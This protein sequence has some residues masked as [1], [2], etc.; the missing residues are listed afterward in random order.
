MDA[1]LPLTLATE[2]GR[3]AAEAPHKPF[4]R[5]LHRE[6]TFQEVDTLSDAAAAGFARL[7]VGLQENVSLLLPNCIE[8]A[9]VW[10]GLAK[11]G[12][13]A[14]PANTAFRGAVLAQAIDLVDSRVLVVHEDLLPALREVQAELSKI[15]EIVVVSRSHRAPAD[16]CAP[17]TQWNNLVGGEPVAIAPCELPFSALTL[18]LYTSG[19]TGRSKAAMI[20]HRFVLEQARLTVR[21][22]G[23][24]TDDVLYCPYPMFH[25]DS[26]VM[27]IAPALVLRCVAAIG[28]RFSV[29][30]YWQEMCALRATVFD[31]M[32]A[33]LTMLWK[34]PPS[35]ADRD[36]CARLGWGVPLPAWA[37]EFEQ[38][39][40]C[41]LVELYGSTEAGAMIFTPLDEARRPGSC[42]KPLGPFDLALLDEDGFAVPDGVA[43]ELV[44][45]PTAPSMLM[46]GYYA[47]PQETLQ[48]FRNLWFHT[49][50]LLKRDADGYLYFVGRRK[51]M[52]RRRG[53]NI[54][55]AEVEM[56]VEE[57]PDI[58][59]CAVYGVPSE[60]TEEEVMVCAVVREGR[61]LPPEALADHCAARMAK[62]MVPRF[63][64]FAT[65][66]PKTP[67]D[68]VEKFWLKQEGV[69]AGT[70]DREKHSAV[71]HKTKE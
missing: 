43:G 3:A 62:F 52:V 18:L 71:R 1:D 12:A 35:P 50:D 2:L 6:W 55:A 25:L 61:A 53:E 33:T 7:G 11:I 58:L 56:A 26:A 59:E 68:K 34:Q 14:A 13:V 22:L 27:T 28:E 24:R 45:R 47:M 9:I 41:R 48:A 31:F 23:L 29:S 8:F 51:D 66:L 15:R 17:S 40:G 4:L 54:S 42:G 36:H 16:L 20:S 60:M 46:D 64:R 49:G 30:R 38:R 70:W 5:M 21:G 57:H 37:G 63:I 69:T 65:A 67:T 19:T 44:L 10:F 39:F 32:G